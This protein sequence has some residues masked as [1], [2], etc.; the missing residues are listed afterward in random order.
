[1]DRVLLVVG[2]RVRGDA[3]IRPLQRLVLVR[4]VVT[5][6]RHTES[7]VAVLLPE[8]AK[9]LDADGFSR[10]ERSSPLHGFH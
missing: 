8:L 5:G 7:G 10:E 4:R 6:N 1:M 9:L 2:V 3:A